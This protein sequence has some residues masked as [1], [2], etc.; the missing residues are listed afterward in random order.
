[1]EEESPLRRTRIDLGGAIEGAEIDAAAAQ[2]LDEIDQPAQCPA[3][4]VQLPHR[5]TIAS[6]EM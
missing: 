5:Q 1:V 4:S 2:L 3:Q 6:A